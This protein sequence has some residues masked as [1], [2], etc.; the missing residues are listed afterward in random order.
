MDDEDYKVDVA[1]GG[2]IGSDEANG[3]EAADGEA[4]GDECGEDSVVVE[5]CSVYVFEESTAG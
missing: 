1:A 5:H 2:V 3:V 4:G